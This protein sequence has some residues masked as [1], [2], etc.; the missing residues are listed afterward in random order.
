MRNSHT[1]APVVIGA[2]LVLLIVTQVSEW[3]H[4][5]WAVFWKDA[6]DM[7][8]FYALAAI[9]MTY[10]G[11]VLRAM[12]WRVFLRPVKT[13]SV[14]QL[15]GPTLVGFTGLAL[16]GRLGELIR[17]Y[18]IARK[19]QLSVSSQ[20]A[21]LAV[22]RVFDITAVAALIAFSLIF[23]PELQSL[24][25]LANFRNGIVIL[26]TLAT[27]LALILILFARRGHTLSNTLQQRLTAVSRPLAQKVSQHFRVFSS[28]LNI[29]RDAKSLTLIIILSLATWF[30]NGLSV[31]ATVHAFTGARQITLGGGILLLG[32]TVL[33]SL[34]QIPGGGNQQLV[35][36]AALVKMFSL[37]LELAITCSILGWFTIFMAP[38]PIGL[39]LLRHEGFTLQNLSQKSRHPTAEFPH[40]KN[41]S[42][43]RAG[44]RPEVC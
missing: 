19:G 29:I 7:S 30:V 41:E 42:P 22:E 16:L 31:L 40:T 27:L 25:Y 2:I 17:P 23:S 32:F 15:L 14:T 4:F 34:V 3:R 36:I 37:R 20:I 9:G 35:T 26:V 24:P 21:A 8:L 11:F 33:G 6:R 18:M 12:R 38:V 28:E 10:L 13:V 43:R 44:S 5:S 1:L 39:I